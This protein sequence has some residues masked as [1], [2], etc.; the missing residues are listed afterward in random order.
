MSCGDII[1]G[2]GLHVSI[3]PEKSR[4]MRFVY[5]G[6]RKYLHHCQFSPL[7]QDFASHCMNPWYAFGL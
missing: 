7:V 1:I 6:V 2:S 4:T 3:R 5:F